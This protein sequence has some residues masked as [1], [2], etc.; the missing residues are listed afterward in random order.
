M[1]KIIFVLILLTRLSWAYL[2]DDDENYY[3]YRTEKMSYILP[4]S[5]FKHLP[6]LLGQTHNMMSLYEIS[7]GFR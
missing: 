4:E 7:L 6:R 2:V 3:I 1:L 5:D